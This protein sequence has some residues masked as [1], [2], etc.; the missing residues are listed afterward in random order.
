MS[1][2]CKVYF[3]TINH[4]VLMDTRSQLTTSHKHILPAQEEMAESQRKK[5]TGEEL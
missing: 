1:Y 3:N 2:K 4:A 5:V